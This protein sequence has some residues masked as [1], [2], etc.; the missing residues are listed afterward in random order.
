MILYHITKKKHLESIVVSGLIINR[1]TGL[2]KYG[3]GS[4]IKAVWLTDKPKHIIERQ[5][6]ESYF[7][8]HDW[9][10]LT[11]DVSGLD[12][13]RAMYRVW[14][15][16]RKFAF[17]EHEFWCESIPNIKINFGCTVSIDS[18]HFRHPITE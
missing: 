2:G 17:Y 14:D 8:S 15:D 9:I 12:W 4:R 6:G 1:F 7:N 13:C 3:K 10:I 11:V 16:D 5:I 18:K